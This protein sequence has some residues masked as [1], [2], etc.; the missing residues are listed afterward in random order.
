MRGNQEAVKMAGKLASAFSGA[1]L[2]EFVIRDVRCFAGENRVPIRPITLLVGENSTGKTT[3]LGCYRRFVD[4]FHLPPAFVPDGEFSRPPFS[5]GG[6]SDIVRRVGNGKR[7][8]HEFQVGGN[9]VHPNGIPSSL[10]LAYSFGET[11]DHANVVRLVLRFP[12]NDEFVVR[13]AS[14]VWRDMTGNVKIIMLNLSGPG[15]DCPVV[16]ADV[17]GHGLTY[18]SVFSTI[19]LDAFQEILGRLS[20]E[21][22][23]TL[24]RAF[25][26]VPRDNRASNQEMLDF[27]GRKFDIRDKDT[28]KILLMHSYTA[29]NLG[30]CVAVSPIRPM[31]HRSYETVLNGNEEERFLVEMSR[32]SRVNPKKWGELRDGLVEFG[33]KSGM[34]SRLEMLSRGKGADAPFSLRVN[35]RGVDANIA[36]VGYGVSQ[37]LPFLGRVVKASLEK[38]SK[39]FLFQ[40]PE[41]HLHPRAQAEFASFIAESAKKNGHTFLVETHSDFIVDRVRICVADGLIDPEDVALLYFEPQKSGGKV[42]IHRIEMNNNGEPAHAPPKGYREFFLHE[43]ERVLGFRD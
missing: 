42:K 34:F 30:E 31:P 21:T 3:L 27:L 41:D 12:D 39:H 24:E 7:K 38:D 16:G 43:T 37:L 6:F 26:S 17:V 9:I 22:R 23:E 1:R 5:M 32:M 36:D 4:M 35:A 28:R 15:F 13:N 19:A 2:D 25:P 33:V 29:I 11:D 18:R 8:I 40:Q 10:S 14:D 20:G